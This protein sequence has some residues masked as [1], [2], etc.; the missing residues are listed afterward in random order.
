MTF[1]QF[2]QDAY[3]KII[4]FLRD[5]FLNN[6]HMSPELVNKIFGEA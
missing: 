3:V 1:D 4:N 5:L 6:F 2:I